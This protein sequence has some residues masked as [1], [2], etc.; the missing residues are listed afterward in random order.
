MLTT[1]G[2]IALVCASNLGNLLSDVWDVRND[3]LRAGN[4]SGLWKLSLLTS[5]LAMLPIL[6]LHLLPNNAEEQEELAKS[7]ER[8][9][10]AGIV[11]LVVLF[12]SLTWTSVSAIMRVMGN[13]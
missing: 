7:K 12:G 8:S 5:A 13:V 4:V 11:F 3:T 2:N 9:R 10:P 6:W 1:F